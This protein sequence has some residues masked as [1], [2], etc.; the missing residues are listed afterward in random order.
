MAGIADRAKLIG[1][2]RAHFISPQSNSRYRLRLNVCLGLRPELSRGLPWLSRKATV[3]A[4]VGGVVSRSFTASRTA[5]IGWVVSWANSRS[6]ATEAPGNRTELS[7]SFEG[8]SKGGIAD[9][10]K[11][12]RYGR[13]HFIPLPSRSRCRSCLNIR[14]RKRPELSSGALR[15]S[16]KSTVLAAAGPVRPRALARAV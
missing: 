2:G 13:A 14:S 11:L 3:L 9:R 7:T 5:T 16:R 12:I 8:C 10:V 4:T 1:H 6:Q 15:F